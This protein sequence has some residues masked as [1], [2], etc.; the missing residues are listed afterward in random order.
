MKKRNTFLAVALLLAVVVL[1]VGYSAATGQWVVNGTATAEA[2]DFDVA[3]TSVDNEEIASVVSDT[4]A[5]MEVSLKEVGD[6]K[7][8]IF[9]ITNK[10]AKGIGA[11]IPE[12]VITYQDENGTVTA[13]ESAYFEVT[14]KLASNT[15]ASN[16]GTTTLEVTVTLKK[17]AS[18]TVSEEFQVSLGTITAVQE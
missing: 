9:T 1:G 12:V 2:G 18:T 8:A 16:G 11:S 6:S 4:E 7:T 17:A 5:N 14:H 15:I 3:F 10:S 13:S